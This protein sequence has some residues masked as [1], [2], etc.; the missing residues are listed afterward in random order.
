MKSLI[1]FH[2]SNVVTHFFYYVPFLNSSPH[3]C[4]VIHFRNQITNS[5]LT[6]AG[7]E[8]L[9][10]SPKAAYPG[11]NFNLTSL[12]SPWRLFSLEITFFQTTMCCAFYSDKLQSLAFWFTPFSLLT[13]EFFFVAHSFAN[14]R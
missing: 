8:S 1:N 9:F 12:I 2:F 10:N 3:I 7:S 11:I 5:C 14:V 13:F 6:S 4:M